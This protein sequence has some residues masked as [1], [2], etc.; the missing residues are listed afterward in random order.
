MSMKIVFTKSLLFILLGSFLIGC[1][2][3][4]DNDSRCGNDKYEITGSISGIDISHYFG[5]ILSN[6]AQNKV[7]TLRKNGTFTLSDS[8]ISDQ[9]YTEGY[10]YNL[11]IYEFGGDDDNQPYFCQISN[12]TGIVEKKNIKDI[13]VSCNINPKY[14]KDPPP[15]PQCRKFTNSSIYPSNTPPLYCGPVDNVTQLMID[16]INSFW[17]SQMYACSC[18]SDFIKCK[19]NAIVFGSTPTDPGYGYIY[20]DD[21]F[22]V[23]LKN[24]SNTFLT[25]AWL[26]S[27][28]AGHN[29]QSAFSVAYPSTALKELSADC[30]S[31]YFLGGLICEGQTNKVEVE[32]TLKILCTID[33]GQ[34]AFFDPSGH[35]SCQER[36]SSISQ[37]IDSYLNGALPLE[38]C[39]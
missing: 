17:G 37:G 14:N 25:P 20:Y 29:V 3:E 30:L 13:K 21:N 28:E 9:C 26:L 12:G 16:D 31:G 38:A 36:V 8:S 4:D 7:T 22:L 18:G 5:V 23:Y 33:N 6:D 32:S 11:S 1:F 27:H 34:S 24:I 10:E 15:P 35:G 19:G 2:H 39:L